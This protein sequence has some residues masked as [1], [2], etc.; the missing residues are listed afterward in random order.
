MEEAKEAMAPLPVPFQGELAKSVPPRPLTRAARVATRG[1]GPV[2]NWTMSRESLRSNCAP[3]E[4]V[5]RELRTLVLPLPRP[6]RI[7]TVDAEEM[8]REAVRMLLG[9]RV[10]W[11]VL[12]RA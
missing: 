10:P 9:K 12:V 3:V 5:G 6:E 7:R 2:P 4:T 11:P 8:L 1:E